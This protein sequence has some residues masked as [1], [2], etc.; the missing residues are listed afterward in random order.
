[1][2]LFLMNMEQETK[3]SQAPSN[4][5]QDELFFYSLPLFYQDKKSVL[6]QLKMIEDD[7]H[8]LNTRIK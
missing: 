4:L 1:M 2:N 7:K 5:R 3:T 6:N 8:R